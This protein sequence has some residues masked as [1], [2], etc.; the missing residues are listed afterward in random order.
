MVATRR[1]CMPWQGPDSGKPQIIEVVMLPLQPLVAT[2]TSRRSQAGRL[3]I[4]QVDRSV[5][6]RSINN[7]R[8]TPR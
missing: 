5:G 2:G 6:F 8:R 3:L 1:E 4:H 7:L